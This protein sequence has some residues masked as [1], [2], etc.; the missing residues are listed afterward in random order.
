MVHSAQLRVSR[1]VHAMPCQMTEGKEL[2]PCPVT[3]ARNQL[4][5]LSRK[6]YEQMQLNQRAEM[7]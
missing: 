4:P 6:R 7:P 2:V 5:P 1:H 3:P